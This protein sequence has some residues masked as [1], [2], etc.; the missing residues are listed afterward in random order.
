MSSNSRFFVYFRISMNYSGMSLHTSAMLKVIFFSMI[1]SYF[2]FFV[3]DLTPIQGRLP[4]SKYKSTYIIPSRSSRLPCSIPK[5]VFNDAYLAV[6]VKFLFSLYSIWEPFLFTSFFANPKSTIYTM[7]AFLPRPMR[8]LSG[9]TS[10]WR[11]SFEWMNYNLSTICSP[12]I[13]TVFRENLL[14]HFTNRSSNEL[15]SLSMTM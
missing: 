10:R 11:T 2:S 3:S 13:R 15:P 7:W 8:K 6:P 4:Y 5:C 1:L 14:P 12:I 9:L